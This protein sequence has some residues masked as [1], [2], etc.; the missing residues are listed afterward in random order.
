M[1]LV[2]MRRI[3]PPRAIPLVLK[4]V[5]IQLVTLLTHIVAKTPAMGL[6]VTLVIK[7]F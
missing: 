3:Q 5:V 6:L 2:C 1:E 7:A 4:Q